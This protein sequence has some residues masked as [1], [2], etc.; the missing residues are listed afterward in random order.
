MKYIQNIKW[1]NFYY[2]LLVFIKNVFQLNLTRPKCAFYAQNWDIFQYCQ[3]M[4][5]LSL[6]YLDRKKATETVFTCLK[7]KKG[8]LF[9]ENFWKQFKEIGLGPAQPQLA[10]FLVTRSFTCSVWKGYRRTPPVKAV[11]CHVSPWLTHTTPYHQAP[12]SPCALLHHCPAHTGASHHQHTEHSKM[13]LTLFYSLFHGLILTCPMF[14]IAEMTCVLNMS[15]CE[16]RVEPLVYR[17]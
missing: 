15:T 17:L 1:L 16:A 14:N 8:Y 9:V 13:W 10:P 5:F 2:M 4:A 3:N 6:F 11:V 12:S 7:V